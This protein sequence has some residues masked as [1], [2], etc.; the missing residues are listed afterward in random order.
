MMNEKL[1]SMIRQGAE[2]TRGEMAFFLGDAAIRNGILVW[3]ELWADDQHH[4]HADPDFTLR[5]NGNM[6]DLHSA[7]SGEFVGTFEP[8]S[9]EAKRTVNWLAWQQRRESAPWREF[10]EAEVKQ[11]TGG[12]S[13]GAHE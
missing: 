9:D 10:F 6:L 1:I 13:P 7:T 8:M 2:F 12:N 4:V 3:A 11:L 5:E